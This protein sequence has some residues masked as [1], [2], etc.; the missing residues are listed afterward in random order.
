[1]VP[2]TVNFLHQK[3]K[4]IPMRIRRVAGLTLNRLL[5]S[6]NSAGKDMS[7]M[8]KLGSVMDRMNVKLGS[9]FLNSLRIKTLGSPYK[10]VY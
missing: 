7:G 10:C 6:D 4:K 9:M 1:L 5:M 8:D 3:E 2:G